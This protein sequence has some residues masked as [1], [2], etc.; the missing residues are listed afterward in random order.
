MK[1][2]DNGALLIGE[3]NL[4]AISLNTVESVFQKNLVE[5]KKLKSPC[6]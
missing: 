3:R 1:R 6:N 2:K 4:F 5:T